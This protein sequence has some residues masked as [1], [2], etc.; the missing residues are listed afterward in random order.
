MENGISIYSGLGNSFEENMQLLNLAA[1]YNIKRIFTSCH[2]PE[3][4][5]AE[6][7]KQFYQ[8]MKIAAQNDMEVISDIS[9]ATLSL[10][11]LKKLDLSLFRK[12]GIKRLRIDYGYD[13]RFISDLS[14]NMHEINIELNAS[15]ITPEILN[16]LAAQNADFSHIDA[17]HNFYPRPGTGLSAEFFSRQTNFLH[18]NNISVGAFVPSSNRPRPPLKKGLPTLEEH[19]DMPFDLACRHLCA[20]GADSVFIGDSLP[21]VYEIQSLSRL[22]SDTVIIK[23]ELFTENNYIKTLLQQGFTARTDE[24]RDAVRTQESRRIFHDVSIEKANNIARQ[25]GMITLDNN[26]YM[27]YKGELQIIKN[28]QPAD[29]K[30]NVIGQ[31]IP[32]EMFMLRYITPGR[33]F[34]LEFT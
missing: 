18:K 12:K 16:E 31:I 4:N 24:A 1:S 32:D 29:E 3:T 20:F 8:L 22:Q 11:G 7:Q 33:K 25:P 28:P 13:S 2:V 17:L 21:D 6:F 15:T 19:R 5:F 23:A 30:V 9:P 10:L 34:M 27:R 26:G 14:R